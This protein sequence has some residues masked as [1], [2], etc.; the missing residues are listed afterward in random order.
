MPG[1]QT[2]RSSKVSDRQQATGERQNGG[3]A[4]VIQWTLVAI[5]IAT[6]ILYSK[7]VFNGFT[8][9]DD[10]VYLTNNVVIQ[11]LSL[12][13]FCK[14]SSVRFMQAIISR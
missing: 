11:D 3:K 12:R 13:G 8:S 9:L 7:A 6:A 2:I 5:L 1:K 10:D 4:Q 14:L